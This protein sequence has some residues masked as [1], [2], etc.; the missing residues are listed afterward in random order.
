MKRI[1]GFSAVEGL[2]VVSIVVLISLVGYNL[3]SMNQARTNSAKEQQAI[4]NQVPAAPEIKDE[5]DL[6]TAV[7][8]LDSVDVDQNQ[9]ELQSLDSETAF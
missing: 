5:S 8:T 1:S 4:A 7:Q 3:Y 2:I 6:D 9:G